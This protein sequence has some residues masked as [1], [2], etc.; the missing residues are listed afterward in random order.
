MALQKSIPLPFKSGL[1]ANYLR[2]DGF[3]VDYSAGVV[4]IVVGVYADKDNAQ[5]G[6]KPYLTR[7]VRLEGEAAEM[8]VAAVKDSLGPLAYGTLKA[9]EEFTGAKDA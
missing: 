8:L 7:P 6:A 2:V 5:G 3:A 4:E 1:S 9:V